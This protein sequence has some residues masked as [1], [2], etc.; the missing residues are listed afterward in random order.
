V[1]GQCPGQRR[2]LCSPAA[3][4]RARETPCPLRLAS[5]VAAVRSGDHVVKVP[6]V[7]P[8]VTAS[9]LPGPSTSRWLRRSPGLPLPYRP[10]GPPVCIPT[11][12]LGCREVPCDPRTYREARVPRTYLEY[13]RTVPVLVGASWGVGRPSCRAS[14]VLGL[15]GG[16]RQFSDDNWILF[17]KRQ[18]A[19]P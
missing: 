8:R 3:L 12:A 11:H 13:R 10:P 1:P 18:M 19:K 4:R 14:W 9:I 15:R 6:R 16:H 5:I 2:G 17:V 7:S